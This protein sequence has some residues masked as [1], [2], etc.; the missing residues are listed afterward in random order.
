MSMNG[1]EDRVTGIDLSVSTFQVEEGEEQA[2][3]QEGNGGGF[4]EEEDGEIK[5]IEEIE[6]GDDDEGTKPEDSSLKPSLCDDELSALKSEMGRMKEENKMLKMIVEQTM[7]EY[8]DLQLKYQSAQRSKAGTSDPTAQNLQDQIS[9]SL[10][11]SSTAYVSNKQERNVKDSP[12]AEV[13]EAKLPST[14]MDKSNELELS[15]NIQRR[16]GTERPADEKRKQEEESEL[17]I[18]SPCSKNQK[19]DPVVLPSQIP[20][21]QSRK[22]RVSVR[23]R[24][25]G[26]TMNDG[27][28]WRKYG[29]KIAKGNPCPRAY[30]RCTVAPGC[31]VRKQVQR[32]L[33]DMSILITTYEG[34]HNH[35][36]PVGATAMAS[37]TAAATFMLLSG[38]NSTSTERPNLSSTFTYNPYVNSVL[39][40]SG[41]SIIPSPK[42][43]VLDLTKTPQPP[44]SSPS[45][46]SSS[47]QFSSW[48][49][50]K[51]S[52]SRTMGQGYQGGLRHDSS[53]SNAP[54]L[55][56]LLNDQAGRN[57]P[58]G[59][60]SVSDNVSAIASDPKFTAAIAAALSSYI[61]Q[62]GHLQS[63][64]SS[65]QA[66]AEGS[67]GKKWCELER[68]IGDCNFIVNLYVEN[69][70]R[71][72]SMDLAVSSASG[73]NWKPPRRTSFCEMNMLAGNEEMTSQ[74]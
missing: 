39:D 7:K 44:S 60:Q 56:K 9:L 38:M 19:V 32:C 10:V 8:Y 73:K 69:F 6:E 37:T 71:F 28:Q 54:T 72:T 59:D 52:S 45:P 29:Q 21:P 70:L 16:S 48:L 14:A 18:W 63:T 57:W 31:P 65:A 61:N 5:E 26:A 43:I 20:P 62:G 42:G 66:D 2:D 22:A 24:C 30:Y 17:K 35:P 41:S 27:C 1:R 53:S 55:G 34:T 64:N 51:P 15:L 50:N 11:S 3:G 36:L 68:K 58:V 33:E 40:N 23:A 12:P 74:E 67:T 47:F 46:P 25:Q 4:E 13:R 49:A